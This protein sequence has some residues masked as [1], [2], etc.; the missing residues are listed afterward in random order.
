MKKPIIIVLGLVLIV[1]AAWF[2]INKKQTK[3]EVPNTDNSL[4]GALSGGVGD[5]QPLEKIPNVNPF[6]SVETNPY[7]QGYTNPFGN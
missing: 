3:T 1:L 5:V 2:I 4:G 7:K 6:N